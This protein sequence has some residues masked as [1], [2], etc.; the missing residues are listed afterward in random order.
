MAGTQ[1]P[2]MVGGVASATAG[3]TQTQADATALSGAVNLVTTGNANDGVLLPASPAA[4]DVVYIVNLSAA[5]LKVYPTTGGK[6]NNGSANAAVSMR[7]NT[8]GA[9]VA[10]G[11]GNWGAVFD[12]DTTD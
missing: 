8:T 10:T 7:A 4:G 6:I 9:F 12:T 2:R 11:S 3:T 1:F 5:V